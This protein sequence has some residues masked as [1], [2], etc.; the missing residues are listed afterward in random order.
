MHY[1]SPVRRKPSDLFT[2]PLSDSVCQ[3][4]LCN[5][6]RDDESLNNARTRQSNGVKPLCNGA[7]GKYSVETRATV[8]DCIKNKHSVQNLTTTTVSFAY[9]SSI[10]HMIEF[11]S[12]LD[13][14][15]LKVNDLTKCVIDIR[16]IGTHFPF[17]TRRGSV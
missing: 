12:K 14:I 3:F 1:P 8:H 17:K 5:G 15:F 6:G 2:D 10:W 13:S 16:F 4:T 7:K 11:I 9:C